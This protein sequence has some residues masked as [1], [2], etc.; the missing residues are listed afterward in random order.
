MWRDYAPM[1]IDSVEIDPVVVDVARRYFDMPEDPRLRV[2]TGDARQY[3]ASTKDRYDVIVVDAYYS[4]SLPFHLATTEFF[5]Q[6]RGILAPD[7][8]VAYN[9]ISHV[10]GGGSDLFRSFRKTVGGVWRNVY[11]FPIGIS[12]D[13]APGMLR[14]GLTAIYENAAADPVRFITL[15]E[16]Y[17]TLEQATDEVETVANILEG[18]VMKHSS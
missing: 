17:E 10:E 5:Q 9:V 11:V 12:T 4:D 18:V 14:N 15:K 1:R 6:V 7:G 3:V 13:R 2:F 8:V 16:I